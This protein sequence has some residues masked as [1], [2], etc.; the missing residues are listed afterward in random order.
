METILIR[1]IPRCISF[2]FGWTLLLLLLYLHLVFRCICMLYHG[3]VVVLTL[4]SILCVVSRVVE[5]GSTTDAKNKW[6]R[7]YCDKFRVLKIEAGSEDEL[8]G[9]VGDKDKCYF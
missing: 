7:I 4:Y 1:I 5:P 8:A 2:L 3:V 6:F 9:R